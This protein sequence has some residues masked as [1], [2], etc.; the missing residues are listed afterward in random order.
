MGFLCHFLSL[1]HLLFKT[2]L[3]AKYY[4]WAYLEGYLGTLGE[5]IKTNQL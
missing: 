5:R 4:I 3:K 1:L 2:K